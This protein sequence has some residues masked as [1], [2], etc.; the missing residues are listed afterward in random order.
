MS[1]YYVVSFYRLFRFVLFK[2]QWRCLQWFNILA[3]YRSAKVQ[4][5]NRAHCPGVSVLT[6]SCEGKCFDIK[7]AVIIL[8]SIPL[9]MH[10]TSR[11]FYT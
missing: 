8:L 3:V 2:L 4:V 6:D 5:L 1:F 10:N 11:T 9:L 7:K